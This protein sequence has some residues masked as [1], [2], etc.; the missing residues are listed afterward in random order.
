MRPSESDEI[1]KKLKKNSFQK[2]KSFYNFVFVSKRKVDGLKI[3]WPM[4]LAE[5]LDDFEKMTSL[6]EVSWTFLDWLAYSD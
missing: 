3:I 1:D 4:H 6:M 2:K 5:T